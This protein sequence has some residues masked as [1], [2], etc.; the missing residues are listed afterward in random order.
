MV[1]SYF[2]Y[3]LLT[4]FLFVYFWSVNKISSFSVPYLGYQSSSFCDFFGKSKWVYA[5]PI[6]VLSLVLG[7]RYN[8]GTD[9]LGYKEM[10]DTQSEDLLWN[11]EN[12]RIEP[13]YQIVNHIPFLFGL[14]YYYMSILVCF[15]IF[16]LFYLSFDKDRDMLKWYCVTLLISGTLFSFL[17]IQRHAIA[18]CIFLFSIRYIYNRSLLKYLICILIAMGF[19]YSSFVLLPCYLL[20]TKRKIL[21]DDWRIQCALC[22]LFAFF[23][24]PILSYLFELIMNYAPRGYA[25]YGEQV[26]SKETGLSEQSLFL[27][28]VTILVIIIS[29]KYFLH[30]YRD[31]IFVVYYRLYFIGMLFTII[32]ADSIL[33]SRLVYPFVSLNFI[34]YAYMYSYIFHHIRKSNLVMMICSLFIFVIT[35]ITFL[36][37][38]W[39]SVHKCSPFQFVNL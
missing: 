36:F 5:I 22:V 32:F 15:I 37:Y 3:L 34:V 29:S 38:I 31:K 7:L 14:P 16:S 2:I 18:F 23:S 17:N 4:T 39:N 21:I 24:K 1:E 35:N 30:W 8:V 27:N 20:G 13:L 19:H 6:M 33:L 10:Y 12:E 26:F 11:I 28:F 9:Y 25:G